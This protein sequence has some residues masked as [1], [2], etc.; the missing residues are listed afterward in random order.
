MGWASGSMLLQE[1]A[2]A[3]MPHLPNNA[4]RL[5]VAKQLVQAFESE[6]CDTIDEVDDEHIQA[7]YRILNPDIFSQD[8]DA[9]GS[10]LVEKEDEDDE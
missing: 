10:V 4:T 5:I 9:D 6:D 7:A 1:V 2:N 3:V 8:C